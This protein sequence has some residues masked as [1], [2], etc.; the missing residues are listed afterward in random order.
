M[1]VVDALEHHSTIAEVTAYS[2]ILATLHSVYNK[3]QKV[4]GFYNKEISYL[5]I[6]HV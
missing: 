4:N 2:Y 6:S 1:F 5:L 3:N